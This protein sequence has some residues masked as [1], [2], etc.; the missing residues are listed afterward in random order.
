[1]LNPSGFRL[2]R[3]AA[4]TVSRTTEQVYLADWASPDF[5]AFRFQLF[6]ALLLGFLVVL[7]AGRERVRP[8]QVLVFSVFAFLGLQSVRHIPIFAVVAVPIIVTQLWLLLKDREA[9]DGSVQGS[10]AELPRLNLLIFGVVVLLMG[11][12]F[13]S[14]IQSE[15]VAEAQTFP[16]AAVDFIRE[17]QLPGPMF[18]LYEW[19]GYLIWNLYPDRKVFVDGRPEIYGDDYIREYANTYFGRHHW[20]EPLDRYQIRT[21][22]IEPDAPLASLLREAADWRS[23]FED[24]V[25][26][27]FVR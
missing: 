20:R 19:G 10:T 25:A 14:F 21:V 13:A 1:V 9:P 11:Y 16:R 8:A 23:V 4:E 24:K 6:A 22:V 15:Q 18:N 3:Y 26:V 7:A 17:E 5:H 27:V 2:Y 12:R